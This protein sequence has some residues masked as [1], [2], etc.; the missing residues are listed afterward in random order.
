MKDEEMA[1]ELVKRNVCG[2]CNRCQSHGYI[3]CD[4]Y[5]YSKDGFL[6]GLKA[7]RPQWHDLRKDPNDLPKE[8]RYYLIYTVLGNYY[9]SKHHH[10]TNYWIGIQNQFV[11]IK[12]VI[13]WCEIPTFDKE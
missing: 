3:G 13:A 7:G 12:Q 8:D 5:R 1:E 2:H 9:V 11:S 4:I 10:N 6:A